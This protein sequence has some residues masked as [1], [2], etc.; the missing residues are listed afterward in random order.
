[1]MKSDGP[2]GE[3]EA[4]EQVDRDQWAVVDHPGDFAQGRCLP[5]VGVGEQIETAPV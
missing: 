1:M 4:V 2:D 3:A 5:V